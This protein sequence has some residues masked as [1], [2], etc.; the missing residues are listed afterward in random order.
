MPVLVRMFLYIFGSDINPIQT[1]LKVS[2]IRSLIPEG[3][4]GSKPTFRAGMG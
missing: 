4:E 3:S 2:Q 1:W